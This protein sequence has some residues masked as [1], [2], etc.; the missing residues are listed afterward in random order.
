MLK[1]LV[2]LAISLV[3]WLFDRTCDVPG[4]LV[5]YPSPPRGTVIYY[6]GVKDSQRRGFGRQMD[7]LLRVANPWALGRPFE[8]KRGLY[9]AVTFDDGF[10]SVVDNAAPELRKRGIPF[11]V[12]VPTGCWGDRPSWIKRSAHPSWNER[13]VTQDE[14]RALTGEPLVT[15]GSAHCLS[16]QADRPGR[17]RSGV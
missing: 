1:R 2:K 16:P 10:V 9:V 4:W 6:H 3:V 17:H 13:V 15:I 11:T 7:N 14:L 5:R 12:F 8:G